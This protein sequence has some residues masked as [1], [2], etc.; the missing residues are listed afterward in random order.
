MANE[1]KYYFL[2][3]GFDFPADSVTLGSII[4]DLSQPHVAIFTPENSDMIQTKVMSTDKYNFSST[5]TDKRA[6]K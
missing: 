6:K 3:P 1:V 2:A 5:V 4:T